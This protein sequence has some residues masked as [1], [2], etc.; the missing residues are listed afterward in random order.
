MN[1]LSLKLIGV[2]LVSFHLHGCIPVAATGAAVTVHDRR[3][4]GTVIDDQN[5][6]FKV[7]NL[8][9]KDP[10]LSDKAHIS[11]TSYNKI[12]LLTGQTPTAEMRSRS[13][14]LARSVEHVRRVQNELTIEDPNTLTNRSRDTWLTSKVKTSMVKIDIPGFDITR[15]KVV[16][17]N[18]IVFL[19]GLV[20]RQESEAVIDVV[21]KVKG[22]ERIIK[23]FEYVNP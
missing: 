12:V 6:E 8:I 9:S 5:I 20:T 19:M 7:Y 11:V 4:T 2:I 3:T 16:T 17:E 21:K 15:V 10:E 18:R 14:S 22:I 13:E 1:N 23:V